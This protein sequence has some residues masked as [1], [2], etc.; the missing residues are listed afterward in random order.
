MN[1]DFK[2]GNIGAFETPIDPADRSITDSSLSNLSEQ[3]PPSFDSEGFYDN[4][5]PSSISSTPQDDIRYRQEHEPY[6]YQPD[7][8]QFVYITKAHLYEIHPLTL[9]LIKR[10]ELT[11]L[12]IKLDTKKRLRIFTI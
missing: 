3:P 6:N 12:K 11:P 10:H 9:G 5:S 4:P 7:G 1:I 8:D 2:D